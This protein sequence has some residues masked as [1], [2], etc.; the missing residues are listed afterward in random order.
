MDASLPRQASDA[1]SV[2]RSLGEVVDEICAVKPFSIDLPANARF[3][4]TCGDGA[5]VSLVDGKVVLITVSPTPMSYLL[6]SDNPHTASVSALA[7]S[8]DYQMAMTGT[9]DGELKLWSVAEKR[10]IATLEGHTNIFAVAI[11]QDC[12]L[13]ISGGNPPTIKVWDLRNGTERATL[14]GH[15][16]CVSC[17]VTTKD[18]KRC[19]SGDHYGVIKIWDLETMQETTTLG[20]KGERVTYLALS[21]DGNTL[22]SHAYETLRVWSLTNWQELA[23]AETEIL[24]LMRLIRDGQVGVLAS[25]EE[26]NLW[27]LPEKKVI[28]LLKGR[29]HFLAIFN[30]DRFCLVSF[31]GSDVVKL[32]DFESCTEVAFF[33][34][35]SLTGLALTQD[36]Q[37]FL[38]TSHDGTVKIWSLAREEDRV[39]AF[40]E[41]I[42]KMTV[43]DNLVIASHKNDI[44]LR[45][46]AENRELA[47]LQGHTQEI[48]YVIVTDDQR[49][50]LSASLDG[51]IKLWDLESGKELYAFTGNLEVQCIT[52]SSDS[53]FFLSSEDISL[54]L[55][56][57]TGK[58]LVK[59]VDLNSGIMEMVVA[60]DGQHLITIHRSG[61]LSIRNLP[62]LITVAEMREHVG[63]GWGIAI[64]PDGKTLVS[65]G[66]DKTVRMWSF[67]ERRLLATLY[68]HSNS[69]VNIKLSRD[70]QYAI[71]ASDDKT[72]IVWSLKERREVLR[73]SRNDIRGVYLTPDSKYI[74]T[75]SRHTACISPFRLPWKHDDKTELE[76][77]S[78]LVV[79]MQNLREGK[80]LNQIYVKMLLSSYN[81]NSL[82]ISAFYNYADRCSEYLEMGVPFLKGTFGS[83]LTVALERKTIKC[84]DALLKHL[85]TISEE[86]QH[87]I[88]WPTFVCITDD[89][90]ALLRCGSGLLQ[91]FFHILMQTPATYSPL[92]HFI[93][94]TSPLPIVQFSDSRLINIPDFDQSQNGKLGSDLVVFTVG[95]IRQNTAPGS[96]QSLELIAA[97][98]DCE[99]KTVLTSPYLTLLI[100]SKWEYFYY[101]TLTL[102]ILYAVMLA[103]LVMILFQSWN[104]VPL[105]CIFLTINGFFILYELAQALTSSSSYWLDP[106]NYID[107]F[108]GFLCM[109]WGVL[110]LLDQELAFLGED[111]QKNVRL[112]VSLLCFL[113]GFTYFRSFRMTRLFVYLT[114]A[115]VKEMYS[116]LII[117]AYSVFC[118][119]VCTSIL[120]GHANIGVSWTTAFS[121]IL[122]DFDSSTFGALEW[123]VFMC[124]ALINVIIMLNLLVS[125][126][127]DA[128]EKT[129]MSV[130]ENDLYLMLGLI[131]EYESLFCWRRNTG[132]PTILFSC[133][134]AQIEE[135]VQEWAGLTVDIKSAMK[136]ENAAIKM[137]LKE[138]GS[139]A[140]EENAE[141]KKE[142]KE[143]RS[144]VDAIL[145]RLP[146]L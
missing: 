38:S 121:L 100:E 63:I 2:G 87:D 103:S 118:F 98:Q 115:V 94:P 44:T 8:S 83:P 127:G 58:C 15:E 34:G 129:Q 9:D 29:A 67:E 80:P 86:Q 53:Q 117:M 113:R 39:L 33:T 16:T 21:P 7:V 24:Y 97:L 70:A 123:G 135:S 36:E 81:V 101:Y 65:C 51:S 72:V 11:T 144:K 95:L 76:V 138:L 22:W 91:P 85:I 84:T 71:S 55:W 120:L 10:E 112:V 110:I 141:I 122:G 37:H 73:F 19:I 32:W 126:L 105:S 78:D 50:L 27:S 128:Y 69:V 136:Q 146:T 88:E 6:S 68:G 41:E 12:R 18:S 140:D 4:R 143:L 20:G 106:W 124:A 75:D 52:C 89:I 134:N 26:I 62:G 99:D 131:S 82:H 79:A 77:T 49:S 137:G 74:I 92:P 54:K 48:T 31:D 96:A 42:S 142:L 108:R 14:E 23:V 43:T 133:S 90:P 45:S 30:N 116:F 17:L 102:T 111:Y 40:P 114:L 109:F 46:I 59:S 47:I 130:R 28:G 119:G 25:S 57:L 64:T 56:N 61:K 125:I 107:A 60:P 139:K 35:N 1:L 5:I 132:T 104:P 3:M 13:G 93:I 145:A 66:D